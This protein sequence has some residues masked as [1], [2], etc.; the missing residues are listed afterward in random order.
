MNRRTCIISILLCTLCLGEIHA[1]KK[2]VG[3]S[4]SYAGT[5]LVYEHGF[6]DKNFAEVQLRMETVPLFGNR[7]K[8]PGISASFTWNMVLAEKEAGDGNMIKFF[9]G[10]GVMAGMTGDIAGS[11]GIVVG[12]KGRAGGECTF[13]RKV[14][15]SLCIAPVL[16]LH[17]GVREGMVS[18]L[19]YKTGLLYTIMPEVGIKYA[20]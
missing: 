10:P 2:S 9:A 17:L 18:M 12:L 7:D 11:N 19:F 13:S 6:D 15:V 5:G 20:F 14:T 16:G 8:M 4:F 1:Q 3:T